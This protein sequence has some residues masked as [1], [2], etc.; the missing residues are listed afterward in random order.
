MPETKQDSFGKFMSEQPIKGGS[1]NIEALVYD[2]GRT[3]F[4]VKTPQGV[5]VRVLTDPA[6]LASFFDRFLIEIGHE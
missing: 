1:F 3:L 2:D 5:P 4:I 6:E